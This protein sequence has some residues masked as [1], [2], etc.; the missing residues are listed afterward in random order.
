MLYILRLFFNTSSNIFEGY[1]QRIPLPYK[2]DKVVFQ[3]VRDT[4][5]GYTQP[6]L[7]ISFCL[8]VVFQYVRNIFEGYTQRWSAFI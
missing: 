8:L 2:Y 1:T 7:R 5:E 6:I 4:F 3:Y